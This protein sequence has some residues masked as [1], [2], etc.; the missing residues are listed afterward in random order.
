[1][2]G[3][4]LKKLFV[5][6]Y[7]PLAAEFTSLLGYKKWT[8]VQKNTY[9]IFFTETDDFWFA[10]KLTDGRWAVW[11]EEGLM[12]HPFTVFSTWN[13]AIKHLQGLFD[14]SGLPERNWIQEDSLKKGRDLGLVD[15]ETQIQTLL[16]GNAFDFACETL[17]V[18]D[19]RTHEYSE[20]FTVSN[21]EVYEYTSIHGIPHSEA[22]RKSTLV[23]GFHYYKE[24]GKWYTFFMER[25]QISHEKNFNDEEQG[26]RYIVNTLLQLNGTGLY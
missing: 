12:P 15:K 19:M 22:I 13:K 21:E 11:K 10:T 3:K 23:E 17:G 14:E 4:Y 25:G 24:K 20:V 5:R 26:K 1:M 18:N 6:D 9:A 2:I 7:G 16:Y 8:E